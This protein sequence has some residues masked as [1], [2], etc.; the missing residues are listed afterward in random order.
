MLLLNHYYQMIGSNSNQY[1]SVIKLFK[2][3]R[4]DVLLEQKAP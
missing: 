3:Q 4:L 1:V 2:R